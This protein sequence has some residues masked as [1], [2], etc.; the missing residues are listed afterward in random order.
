MNSS[1]QPTEYQESTGR[2]S[3]KRRAPSRSFCD[4]TVGSSTASPALNHSSP[5]RNVRRRLPSLPPSPVMCHENQGTQPSSQPSSALPPGLLEITRNVQQ[6]TPTSAPCLNRDEDA[7]TTVLPVVSDGRQVVSRGERFCMP[8]G[9]SSPVSPSL[10]R[11]SSTHSVRCHPLSPLHRGLLRITQNAR[12]RSLT[13]P[14]C[15]NRDKETPSTMVSAV[16]S[17]C[18]V[19][20]LTSTAQQSLLESPSAVQRVSHAQQN[21]CSGIQPST[22]G[23]VSLTCNEELSSPDFISVPEHSMDLTGTTLNSLSLQ[24]DYDSDEDEN[25]YILEEEYI[26]D[27][28]DEVC[29]DSLSV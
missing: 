25:Y 29:P 14:P 15:L 23:S 5:A 20:L 10:I 7:P 2:A 17:A 28:S 9:D 21:P 27:Y 19:M 22:S 24:P 12:R 18:Q 11:S 4:P 3:R 26:V 8:S 13:P 16:S 1:F 6:H